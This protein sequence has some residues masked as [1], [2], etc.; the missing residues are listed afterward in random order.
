[1]QQNRIID[2]FQ[3]SNIPASPSDDPQERVLQGPEDGNWSPGDEE[4][5]RGKGSGA[6]PSEAE[7]IFATV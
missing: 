7:Q 6:E 4:Q 1:M 2:M 5:D 3:A